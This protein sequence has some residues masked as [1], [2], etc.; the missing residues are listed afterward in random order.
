MGKT[1][2]I[3]AEVLGDS[4]RWSVSGEETLERHYGFVGL[5]LEKRNIDIIRSQKKA[6]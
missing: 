5:A 3:R 6:D 4:S 1:L 2:S